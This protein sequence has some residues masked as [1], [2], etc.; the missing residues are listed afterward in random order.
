MLMLRTGVR[1]WC[2]WSQRICYYTYDWITSRHL[3]L[4]HGYRY[5]MD[6]VDW[7]CTYEACACETVQYCFWIGFVITMLVVHTVSIAHAE[8]S[9]KFNGTNSNVDKK[10]LLFYLTILAFSQ[11]ESTVARC[12]WWRKLFRLLM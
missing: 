2:G 9:K 12:W 11:G 3:T 4:T 6:D 7:T 1:E 10:K 8:K 5:L